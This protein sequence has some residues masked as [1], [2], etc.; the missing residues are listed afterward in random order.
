MACLM[1]NWHTSSCILILC[2]ASIVSCSQSENDSEVMRSSH[3]PDSSAPLVASLESDSVIIL[4]Y[5]RDEV[6]KDYRVVVNIRVDER[7]HKLGFTLNTPLTLTK[8]D[9]IRIS[10]SL[11]S[12]QVWRSGFNLIIAFEN[13]E[14]RS[15]GWEYYKGKIHPFVYHLDDDQ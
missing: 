1:S 10:K 11:L 9:S 4:R 8:G 5:T 3:S 13:I 7:T 6:L 12:A 14:R 15:Y 2:L